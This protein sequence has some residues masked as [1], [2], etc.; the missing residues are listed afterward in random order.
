MTST[1]TKFRINNKK[2]HLTYKDHIDPE[3]WLKWIK[4]ERKSDNVVKYSIVNEVGESGYKHTHILVEFDNKINSSQ[5]KIFDFEALHPQIEKVT[6]KIHWNNT[7]IYHKKQSVPFTNIVEEDKSAN[8]SKHECN[9]PSCMKC[10][11]LHEKKNN[12]CDEHLE[13]MD[14]REDFGVD[15]IWKYSSI[16]EA[17]KAKAGS[18]NIN[19]IGQIAQAMKYKPK[20][21]RDEPKIEW[22]SWQEDLYK[23]VIQKCDN[24]RSIIWYFDE[25][26]GSGKTV[27]AKHMGMY[28]KAFCTTQMDAYHTATIIATSVDAGDPINLVILN[29]A[30]SQES[31]KIYQGLEMIK[32]GMV[33]SQKYVGQTMFFDSPHVVVFAN[34]LPDQSKC[35]K[36]RWDIR[37]LDHTGM[38][39]KRRIYVPLPERKLSPGCKIPGSSVHVAEPDEHIDSDDEKAESPVPEKAESPVPEKAESPIPEKA[40][41]PVPESPVPFNLKPL[42]PV[43]L[44]PNLNKDEESINAILKKIKTYTN[45]ELTN[46]CREFGVSG[47]SNKP[48][49]TL[50]YLLTTKLNSKLKK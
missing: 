21:R 27:F 14:K 6:T 45:K 19:K 23:E 16:S 47:F 39:V 13:E 42:S 28:Q 33:T 34:F 35:S 48:K 37:I 10:K 20:D 17:L 7:V 41:S 29:L 11:I 4:K 5:V 26:G 25:K 15:E 31:H 30:R 43:K 22:R 44:G 9:E 3:E 8:N 24:D 18:L 46:L 12:Y 49:D 50:I 38:K 1:D 32:D 2:F 40:E 36:D